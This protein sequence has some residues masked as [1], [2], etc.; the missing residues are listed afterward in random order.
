MTASSA[1]LANIKFAPS[2]QAAAA[3]AAMLAEAA[4][5]AAGAAA[6]TLAAT[7]PRQLHKSVT[8][9]DT[10]VRFSRKS[11]KEINNLSKGSVELCSAKCPKA[12]DNLDAVARK[13]CRMR[14]LWENVLFKGENPIEYVHMHTY[15]LKI[16]LSLVECTLQWGN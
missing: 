14:S 16:T 9:F 3:A 2:Q 6:A 11:E 8:I 5:A 13:P 12:A 1:K 10:A 15:V 4:A 7:A